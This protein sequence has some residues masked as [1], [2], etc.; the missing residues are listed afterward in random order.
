MHKN[1]RLIMDQSNNKL[2]D[3]DRILQIFDYI[4][5]RLKANQLQLEITIYNE[6]VITMVYDNRPAIKDMALL[7][8]S[9]HI[10]CY[11]LKGR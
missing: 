1:G 8:E 5:E 9:F 7:L 11:R 2:M 3:K 6:T 10:F 4:N